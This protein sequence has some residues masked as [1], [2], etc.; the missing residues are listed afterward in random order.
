[1]NLYLWMLHYMI[2]L[3]QSYE[4]TTKLH[5]LPWELCTFKE[6]LTSYL[7]KITDTPPTIGYVA[8]NQNSILD[9]AITDSRTC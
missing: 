4:H 5:Q 2:A 6:N 9:W 7:L 3:D 1:M 8:Q